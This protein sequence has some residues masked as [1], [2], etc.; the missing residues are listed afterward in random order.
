MATKAMAKAFINVDVFHTADVHS[1]SQM[2]LM[3]SQM[4]QT[5]SVLKKKIDLFFIPLK[6]FKIFTWFWRISLVLNDFAVPHY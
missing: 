6:I 5:Y 3:R 4:I 1:S 2:I